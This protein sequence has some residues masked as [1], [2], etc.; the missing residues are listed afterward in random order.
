MTSTRIPSI[1]TSRRNFLKTAST[2][3]FAALLTQVTSSNLRA[4]NSLVSGKHYEIVGV[5]RTTVRLPYREVPGRAMDRELPHWRYSEI[6]EIKLRSGKVGI[7]ETLLYY[8][9]GVPTD[10]DVKNIIGKNAASLLWQDRLGAGLQSALFDA[11]AKTSD[12]PIHALIGQKNNQTTPLS[13]WNIDTSA[14]DMASE[15]KTAHEL[16]YMSY[17]TKGRPWFDIWRQL[18]LA[19][20]AVPP[21]FKIDMDFNDTLRT[22]EQGMPILKGLEKYPQVDIYE[23]PIPQ[24]D[25]E[26]NKKIHA[27]TRV[28]LAL[29][30]GTPAPDVCVKEDVCDGFVI[31]GGA[32]NVM[33]AGLFC[34]GAKKKFWLQLVGTGLTA[35]YSL[36]FGGV[37]KMA[38]WPAVNC[39][40]LFQ[41]DLLVRPIKL[42]NGRAMVPD[43][44]G[45]GFELDRDAVERYKVDKP[46]SR[47]DPP[48]LIE[49]VFADGR[50][51]VTTN[52]GNGN[53][54][55]TAGN[56]GKYGYYQ[57][58]ADTK[59]VPNDG[60]AR[61]QELYQQ[62]RENGPIVV[63]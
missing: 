30:Y 60:S 38:Q 47:P 50:R 35:A 43:Q 12:V 10:E 20:K 39:H 48:R 2:S 29:H 25:V 26:G 49:T 55:L 5:K 23:T 28:Q 59:L 19:S 15:C 8:T 45:L 56:A 4:A 7:G 33:R 37:L 17:K 6:C 63:K 53:F 16:G 44:P 21:E 51:M 27:A 1:G 46:T 9:W 57:D 32:S 31:G 62:A 42:T 3:T 58:G 36:H 54:M 22:A 61:W 13:W 34:E 52:N 24:S 40:Q 11:V 18:E 41:H 14:E